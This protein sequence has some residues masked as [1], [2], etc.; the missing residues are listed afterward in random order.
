MNK[1][2]LVSI[3]DYS[4]E[5][6]LEVLKIASEFEKNPNRNLLEGKVVASL[7]FEPSTRT[8]LSFETAISRMGGRIV[9]CCIL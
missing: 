2:S 3:T 5:D 6:I 7:F 1:R 8:R 4:K 9:G